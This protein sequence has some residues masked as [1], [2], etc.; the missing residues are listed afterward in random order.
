MCRQ[1]FSTFSL[2]DL[3]WLVTAASAVFAMGRASASFL[4]LVLGGVGVAI[5][6]APM[7]FW[8]L[9]I[10]G[11]VGGA[12]GLVATVLFTLAM[13]PEVGLIVA[14]KLL[15]FV[16]IFAAIPVGLPMGIAVAGVA[17]HL[18]LL[19]EPALLKHDAQGIGKLS[20]RM[21]AIAVIVTC[22]LIALIYGLG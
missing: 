16:A 21:A 5:L 14:V 6:R 3:I 10:R 19:F 4:V 12:L 20:A 7:S 17:Y 22:A 2:S 13:T 11:S 18:V 1:R 15:V 8:T 9:V